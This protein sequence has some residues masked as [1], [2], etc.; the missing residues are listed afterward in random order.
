MTAAPHPSL[1][2]AFM[3]P[4][5]LAVLRTRAE[6]LGWKLVVGDPDHDLKI[7]RAHV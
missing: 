4:Q 7:G 2:G 6:P 3:H 5:T 1:I